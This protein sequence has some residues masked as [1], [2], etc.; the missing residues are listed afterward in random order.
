MY[1]VGESPGTWMGN[2]ALSSHIHVIKNKQVSICMKPVN[3]WH[4]TMALNRDHGMFLKTIT[5]WLS[6]SNQK[7]GSSHSGRYSFGF[8]INL[9]FCCVF[10]E[11]LS[12]F[13]CSIE[14]T[15]AN[16]T[17]PILHLCWFHCSCLPWKSVN[18]IISPSANE[19]EPDIIM[20]Q[21]AA[22]SSE[23][24]VH[25]THRL[26]SDSCVCVRLHKKILQGFPPHLPKCA[27]FT[28]L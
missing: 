9:W 3:T 21:R 13:L 18:T 4:L 15:W 8:L 2:N 14:E 28:A 12:V 6:R 19:Q 7:P 27:T 10:N 20:P 16:S 23:L 25:V 26:K 17:C 5:H 24:C 11:E 1:T 22:T